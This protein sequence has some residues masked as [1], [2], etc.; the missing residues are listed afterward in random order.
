VATLQRRLA[1]REEKITI[2]ERAQSRASKTIDQVQNSVAGIINQLSREV[3]NGDAQQRKLLR[4]VQSESDLPSKIRLLFDFSQSCNKNAI[5]SRLFRASLQGHVDF[6]TRLASTPELQTLFLVSSTTG[7]TFLSETTRQLLLEQ[8]ARTSELLEGVENGNSEFAAFGSV[9]EILDLRIDP[10]RRINL[11]RDVIRGSE[12][13]PEDLQTLLLQ[14]V[15]LTNALRG[16]VKSFQANYGALDRKTSE[17]YAEAFDILSK[18]L[19]EE[20]TECSPELCTKLVKKLVLRNSQLKQVNANGDDPNWGKWGR[21]LY[22]A[23]TGSDAKNA[24]LQDIRAAIEEAAITAVGCRRDHVV[25]HR[26][27]RRH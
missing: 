18:V 24:D 13:A 6:L 4:S 27:G 19:H 2:L 9:G 8:A 20:E 17:R 21:K 10:H 5:S 12:L 25:H 1:E 14:E 23:L 22:F 11:I 3:S 15:M 16:Y 26:N 7:N